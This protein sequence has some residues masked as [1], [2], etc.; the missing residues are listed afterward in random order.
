DVFLSALIN[1]DGTMG[2]DLK[3]CPGGCG[4]GKGSPRY[5]CADCFGDSLYCKECTVERHRENP[6]HRVYMW[7]E[8]FFV[9]TSLAKLGLRI[10]FGHPVHESCAAPERATKDFVVLHINGIHTV[11]VDVCGCEGAR[12]AGTP[13]IQL[14]C[15]GWYP[16]THER[17]QTCATLVLLEKFHQDTLQAKTT[18]YDAYGVL[19]KL[20]DNTGIKPPDRY[21]EWLRMCRG[22]RH[23]FLL[24]RGGRLLAYDCSGVYG[25]QE[26]ELA[27]ICPACPRPGVN[28]PHNW[29][30]A[31]PEERHRY[32]VFLALDACFRLKRLLISSE[33][34]D[35]DLGSGW[36]YMVETASYREYLRTVTDQKEMNTCSSLAAL[37]YANT[38]FSRGYSTTGVGM[39]VCARHEF[40]QPNGV[41]DLQK[42]ERFANMDWIFANIL[43]HINP[44]LFKMI[45]YDIVC[46]WSVDIVNR[47]KALPPMLRFNLVLNILRFVIPKMHIHS[48]TLFC[49]LLFSL[50][51]VLGSAQTDGEGV[52]RPWASIGGVATST[53]GMGPGARHDVL[54]CQ[55]SYWNWQK[56][57]NIGDTLRRRRDRAERELKEQTEAYD[58]FSSYQAEHVPKWRE[59]VLAY[60]KDSTKPS[61]YYVPI[62]GN[63]CAGLTEAEVRLNF[64]KEEAA[65]VARG[66]PTLHNVSPSAFMVVGLDLEEEQRRVRVQA[67]LKKA[68]T[69]EME[70]DL[71]ALRTKLGRG[72]TRFRKLQRAYMAPA[73]QIL[74]AKDLP[75]ETLEEDV[76]L[77]LPS[78]LTPAERARCAAGL[79]EIE[80]LMRDAQCRASLDRLRKQLTIKSR[81]I[82]YKRY[83]SR[84]QGPNTRTRTIVA[85]NESK[86]RLHSEKYQ[87]AWEAL[88]RL[89]GG[90]EALVGFRLLR[91]E[92]IRCMADAEDLSR[93]AKK[94]KEQGDAIRIKNQTLR[95]HG[96]LPS[97]ADVE[98]DWDNDVGAG[99]GENE[100]LVSWIWLG[101]DGSDAS[102]EEGMSASLRVEWCKAFARTR[103]WKEEGATVAEEFLRV[104]LSWEYEAQKWEARAGRVPVGVIPFAEAQGAVAYAL[105]Q[106]EMYRDLKARG[107]ITWMEEKPSRGKK[108]RRYIARAVGAMDA[109]ALQREHDAGGPDDGEVLSEEEEEAELLPDVESDEEFIMGGDGYDD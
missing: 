84:H 65:E 46:I 86:V 83:N 21:H 77:L 102:M 32:T 90:D 69:T 64:A 19:E 63:W 106:A 3:V 54:D 87:N 25:T 56:V 82:S 45:S 9:K 105:R 47:L 95:D 35:P 7:N 58:E 11:N 107:D 109:E 66:V 89:N 80:S 17:P 18:M 72:I 5:R 13:D 51:L 49:Q 91:R 27:L 31:S 12:A 78:A 97:E 59:L 94:R 96:L 44:D 73:L 29:R 22:F 1:R 26:G 20:T 24:K 8:R 2:R 23:L 70:I 99:A 79:P 16:A 101:A 39:G 48:H 108:K 33:L 61:P 103:R 30:D 57:V 42:G 4:R 36:A 6:L 68:G 37:D 14:V 38:K 62:K 50:N 88:R 67:E 34:K 76:P 15:G 85:R 100:R 75:E 55:W 28:L 52:E 41:G 104:G 93:Q 40:V 98:M 43:R 81:L 74:A 71:Q 60:E 92:D 53:R 10:Q